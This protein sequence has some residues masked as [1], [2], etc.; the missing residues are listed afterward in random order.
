[1][2]AKIHSIPRRSGN[3]FFLRWYLPARLY[4]YAATLRLFWERTSL[5]W[6][7]FSVFWVVAEERG[8]MAA[9]FFGLINWIKNAHVRRRLP[10]VDSNNCH[11]RR[12]NRY[13]FW[14]HR[15]LGVLSVIVLMHC[16]W[17]SRHCCQNFTRVRRQIQIVS[18]KGNYWFLSPIAAGNSRV[19][20]VGVN[21]HNSW[22]RRRHRRDCDEFPRMCSGQ[23][24]GIQFTRGVTPWWA[25]FNRR[26]FDVKH[27]WTGTT[28]GQIWFSF[29]EMQIVW[30]L[31]FLIKWLEQ[32]MTVELREPSASFIKWETLWCSW[33]KG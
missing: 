2:F 19:A 21:C 16:W 27:V 6:A 28:K 29:Q 10:Y 14:E 25:L 17:Y 13:I 18:V 5:C 12:W 32:M 33:G 20:G 31:L 23:F 30:R 1:M 7:F 22:F 9:R 15:R 11:R 8:L 26:L 4:R 3:D 24:R